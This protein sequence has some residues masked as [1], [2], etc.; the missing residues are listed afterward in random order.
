MSLRFSSQIGWLAITKTFFFKL[1]LVGF[2]FWT[3]FILLPHS[4]SEQ[5]VWAQTTSLTYQLTFAALGYQDALL[6]GPLATT[7]YT[8]SLPPNWVPQP[9]GFI[10]LNVDYIVATQVTSSPLTAQLE[11]ILNNK[12]LHV[13]PFP[14]TSVLSKTILIGIPPEDLYLYEQNSANSLDLNFIV[15]V[16]CRDA[17]QITL[18]VRNISA[19][20]LSYVERPPVLD[21]ALYP[22]PIY[23]PDSFEPRQVH[24]INSAQPSAGE[25]QAIAMVTAKLGH[26]IGT[27]FAITTTSVIST[28]EAQVADNYVIV[29]GTPDS[30]PLVAQLPLPLPALRRQ[31]KLWSEMPATVVRDQPLTYTL[32]V[33]NSSS[34]DQSLN[35]VDRLPLGTTLAGCSGDCRP[36]GPLSVRWQIPSLKP[37]Q[38]TTLTVTAMITNVISSSMRLEHLATLYDNNNLPL[39]ADSLSTQLGLVASPEK[40]NSAQSKGA[41]F[42]AKNGL[43]IGENDGL[44]QEIQSPWSPSHVVI[45][46]TGLNDEALT[47]AAAALS[48]QNLY[49]GMQGQYAVVQAIQPFTNTVKPISANFTLADLGYTDQTLSGGLILS[50]D[51]KFEVPINWKLTEDARFTLHYAHS[52]AFAAVSSTLNIKLNNL[53]L[54][55]APVTYKDVTTQTV[56]V[57]LPPNSIKPGSNRLSVSIESS[58]SDPCLLITPDRFWLTIFGNSLVTLSHEILPTNHQLDLTL[59]ALPFNSTPSLSDLV[60]ILPDIISQPLIQRLAQQSFV[61]GSMS[62]STT[63]VPRVALAQQSRLEDWRNY[64]IMAIGMPTT[65]GIIAQANQFLP[66]PF[67]PGTNQ[68]VQRVDNVIYR[69]PPD[70]SLG[71]IQELVSPVNPE[72]AMLVAAGTNDAGVGWAHSILGN[73]KLVFDL[74]GNLVYVRQTQM[75]NVDTR[76]L[77]PQSVL[78]ATQQAAPELQ[79]VG[80]AVVALTPTVTLTATSVATVTTAESGQVAAPNQ[81][82]STEVTPQTQPRWL[83]PLLLVSL[84]LLVVAIGAAIWQN[85]R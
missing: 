7:N 37:G 29:V 43:E 66:Q 3:M 64:N 28:V 27:N 79:P 62:N 31:L 58:L 10:E 67:Y 2:C 69:L 44:V 25:L 72:R 48:G 46:A 83:W 6:K 77:E 49:P 22:R 26:T 68:I 54:A 73:D 38:Q 47:K 34:T 30:N 52:A 12:K 75:Q 19:F 60:I 50:R 39:N 53:M 23:Q 65:N 5:L 4:N 11:V 13:E 74:S 80:A 76:L 51:Y 40:I 18:L 82:D 32:K 57:P 35:L 42:F 8:F 55:S 41:Y 1:G 15:D 9:G 63:F 20:N 78:S 21:L 45:I 36:E 70:V 24:I 84:M 17:G 33:E 56:I 14:S 16:D 85:S 59:Y 61:L 81:N 71:L